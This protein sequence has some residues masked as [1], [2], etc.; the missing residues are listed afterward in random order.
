[1]AASFRFLEDMAHADVAFEATGGSASELF[2]AAAG[3]VME[4]MVDPE[5]VG[6]SWHRIIERQDGDPASLLFEWLSYLV[7]LK[8]AEGVLFH[9][10]S[11][12]VDRDTAGGWRLRGE[13]VGESIDPQRHER[14]SDVKA[15]TKHQYDV[16]EE[17]GRWRARVVLDI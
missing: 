16:R 7:Y 13:L 17:D 14:R 6:S 9:R 5:T 10:T 4:T 15:V 3:A 2:T 12:R 1:M 8:D 11:A